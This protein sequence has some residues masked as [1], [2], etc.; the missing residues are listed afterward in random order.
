MNIINIEANTFET[1]M[2]S[3]EVFVRKVE[4]LCDRHIG[5]ELN[6][7]L[8]NQDVCLILDISPRALQTLRD[9]GKLAYTQIDRKVYYKPQDVDRLINN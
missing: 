8:D 4:R 6:E 9:T 5:K 7:W 1:I 3:F 2:K